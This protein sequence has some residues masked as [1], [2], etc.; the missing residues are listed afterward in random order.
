[1]EMYKIRKL[2]N[3]E[4]GMSAVIAMI[5]IVALTVAL[6]AVAWA[7]VSGLIPMGTTVAKNMGATWDNTATTSNEVN[8]SIATAD[9]G[10]F[11]ANL[12][13]TAKNTVTGA[14]SYVTSLV[15]H[16]P[17]G[18]TQ[19]KVGQTFSIDCN[20]SWTGVY[21]FQFLYEDNLIWK[22]DEISLS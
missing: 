21:T 17:S 6:V 10:L 19:I 18:E 2:V 9:A 5:L 22:S 8:F 14:V 20:N 12:N 4:S 13:A 15:S 3:N 1:M 7:W 11:W 16:S